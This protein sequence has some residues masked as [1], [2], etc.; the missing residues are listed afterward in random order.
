M[1]ELEA[2]T[3]DKHMVAFERVTE[4][5]SVPL[6]EFNRAIFWVQIHNVPKRS[7]TQ[8]T[9]EAVGNTIGNVI[10]VAD[11]GDDGA[12]NEFLRVRFSMDI[13]KP[14]PRR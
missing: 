6:L 10:E 7:L 14:L 3:Y 11:P 13:S 5:E 4:I 8:T 2:W 9:G 12:G 1:L